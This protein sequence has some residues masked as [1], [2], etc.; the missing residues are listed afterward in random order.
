[1]N[2]CRRRCTCPRQPGNM[3]VNA[4][5][6]FTA[7]LCT[8]R[9]GLRELSNTRQARVV[10]LCL[11]DPNLNLV[12]RVINS[13]GRTIKYLCRSAYGMNRPGRRRVLHS[14][15]LASML[16][17]CLMCLSQARILLHSQLLAVVC[18]VYARM[19]RWPFTNQCCSVLQTFFANYS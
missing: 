3:Q 1:M 18:N 11:L 17:Y 8:M 2:C 15:S 13:C 10:R 7:P 14:C 5:L 16:T 19:A 4:V 9:R 6:L 12:D